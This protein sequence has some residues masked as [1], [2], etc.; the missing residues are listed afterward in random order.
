MPWTTIVVVIG[1]S[2]LFAYGVLRVLWG[3]EERLRRLTQ[4]VAELEA[5]AGITRARAADEH[6]GQEARADGETSPEEG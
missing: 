6:E 5:A 2:A 4:R 3:V 1:A